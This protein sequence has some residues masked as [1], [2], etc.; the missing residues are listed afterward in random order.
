MSFGNNAELTFS[1]RTYDSPQEE[2]QLSEASWQISSEDGT[3]LRSAKTLVQVDIGSFTLEK[4]G[5]VVFGIDHNGSS[6]YEGHR[7][8]CVQVVCTR[9][10]H[11]P[12]GLIHQQSKQKMI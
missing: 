3:K 11:A 4:K 7:V 8:D 9:D 5:L 10:K 6:T 12:Y 1:I 2:T